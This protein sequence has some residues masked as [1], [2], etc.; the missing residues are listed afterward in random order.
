[1]LGLERGLHCNARRILETHVS[2]SNV[3]E[4]KE[5]NN[6]VGSF[7]FKSRGLLKKGAER[8]EE[9]K[10]LKKKKRDDSCDVTGGGSRRWKEED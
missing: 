4:E 10:P 2:L 7:E 8:R 6:L 1:M 9:N 3:T 5:K